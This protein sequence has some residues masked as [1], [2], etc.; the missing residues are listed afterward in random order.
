MQQASLYALLFLL[1][2]SKAAIEICFPILLVGW[3]LEHIPTRWRSSLWRG[4]RTRWCLIALGAY[5]AVCA[6][7]ILVSSH[8]DLSVRGFVRKTLEYALLFVMAADV[9][10]EP[11]V[12]KRCLLV[13]FG[14]A[15]LVGFDAVAQQIMGKDPLRGHGLFMY[16]ERSK[17]SLFPTSRMT[18]P[19][20]NPGD[21]AT[22]L[23]VIVS[24][25]LIRATTPQSRRTWVLWPLALLLVSVLINTRSQGAWLGLFGGLA[26]VSV[27]VQRLR[28]LFVGG[29][30]GVLL[31]T[32]VLLKASGG[33]PGELQLFDVGTGDRLFIWQAGWHMVQARP[34]LGH[35]LNTFMA[36]YL[37]YWVGGEQQPRY[38]H[39][40]FLQVAAETGVLGLATFAWLL[41]TTLWL[42][43]RALRVLDAQGHARSSPLVGL[44]AGL[45][46]FLI[47]SFFDTNF[48]ALRQATLFWTLAGVATGL[49]VSARPS[50]VAGEAAAR[51]SK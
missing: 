31:V 25:V 44:S 11:R 48:Y 29:C 41:G 13:V 17:A 38:A 35:G 33:L 42:W 14:S 15:C 7:S 16:G 51:S 30:L 19:Y 5:L 40:C 18:G 32:G 45:I 37:A 2:F 3:L 1:P 27:L 26:V 8:P 23:M 50:T 39:N 46:G 9:A 12:A 24:I 10:K 28:R 6:L 34:V 4:P 20:E 36:N 22:Y 49:A 43:G 21:L 47:Q